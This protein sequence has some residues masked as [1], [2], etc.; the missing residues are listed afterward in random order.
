MHSS[1]ISANKVMEDDVNGHIIDIQ[2]II[3]K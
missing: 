1:G 3:N 2:N